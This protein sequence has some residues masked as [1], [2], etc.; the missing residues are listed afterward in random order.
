MTKVT[1]C[2]DDANED[3]VAVLEA[4]INEELGEAVGIINTDGVIETV[5]VAEAT[6]QTVSAVNVHAVSTILPAPQAEQLV[7][8]AKLPP[9]E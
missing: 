8:G 7:H 6:A 2:S 1:G 4:A 5:G 9:V 3:A